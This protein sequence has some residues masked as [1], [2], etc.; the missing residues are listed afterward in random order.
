VTDYARYKEAWCYFD[1]ADYG[2]SRE[3]FT[4]LAAP[5][6]DEKLSREAQKMLAKLDE[7]SPKERAP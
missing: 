4:Q 6:H 3:L 7:V 1:L 2:K 5:G